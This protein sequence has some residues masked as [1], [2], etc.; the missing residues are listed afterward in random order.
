MSV[1]P[2]RIGVAGLGRMGR[3]HAENLAHRVPDVELTRV[4][5]V[6]EETARAAG[7]RLGAAWSTDVEELLRDP[8]LDGV[9][10]AGPTATH[11]PM[12][13]QAAAH[14]K[15]VLCEKP[16]SLELDA[17]VR[18]VQAARAAGI[19]L[20]M[21]FHRRFDPDWAAVAERIAAGELGEAYLLRISLR[22]Q[23]PP[24]VEFLRGSGG[25]FVDVAIHALDAARWLLGEV[26]E[27]AA[28]GAA[29][30]DA[31]F[32]EIGDL[33]TAI[34]QLRFASGALGVIDASRVAGYGY[35]S[36]A[37][38]MGSRAT[39]RLDNHRRTH[40]ERLAPG[41]SAK[42]RVGDFVERYRHAYLLELEAFADAI[43][44]DREPAVTGEDAL[45][46]FVLAQA[47]DEALRER[48][49]V[50]VPTSG[51]PQEARA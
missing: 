9:V 21:G 44:E 7:E 14:G 39:L 47:C 6:V 5:D 18:A 32:A 26:E 35:E 31:V 16:L 50:Q 34:V 42:D 2:I 19:K 11:A 29:T 4:V 3:V 51:A 8:A 17:T 33:D 27:V 37:E 36:S 23:A 10:I 13:E 49:T 12:I 41:A 28:F 15:H 22:D 20:Q 45:A 24:G 25:I 40:V 48:R 46:A 1:R 30:S 38:V 43:R